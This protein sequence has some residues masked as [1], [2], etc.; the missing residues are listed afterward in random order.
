MIPP[1]RTGRNIMQ[2]PST[3]TPIKCPGVM[4]WTVGVRE[5]AERLLGLPTTFH[6]AYHGASPPTLTGN[7]RPGAMTPGKRTMYCG[8]HGGGGSGPGL[9]Q[10]SPGAPIAPGE[11]GAFAP[12]VSWPTQS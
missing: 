11:L 6:N 12:D 7:S 8:R 9:A 4:N 1:F 2:A 5:F 10:R 3:V